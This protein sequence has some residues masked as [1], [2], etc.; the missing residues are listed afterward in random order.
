MDGTV[1]MG[2]ARR[3][4]HGAKGSTQNDEVGELHIAE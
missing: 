3:R 1:E 2:V 4:G